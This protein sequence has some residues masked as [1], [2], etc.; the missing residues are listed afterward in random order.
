MEHYANRLKKLANDCGYK[1]DVFERLL[2][3]R[4]ATGIN[5]PQLEV[6][7]KQ[8]WPDL[9][10][11]FDGK[12]VEV[13]FAKFFAVAQ[14]RELAE[15]DNFVALPA[16][17][18][19]VR[20]KINMTQ[21]NQQSTFSRRLGLDQCRRCG[22]Y[23]RHKVDD[24][25]AR[26]HTCKECQTLGHFEDC[27]IKSGRAYLS[28]TKSGKKRANKNENKL[29]KIRNTDSDEYL[30]ESSDTNSYNSDDVFKIER[31]R[32]KDS[33]RI[34]VILNGVSCTLD[35]DPGSV[36]SIISTEFWKRIGTPPLTK[37]PKLRA[38]GNL[39]LKPKG[40]TDVTV[41]VLGRKKILPVV[42]MEDANPMLFGLQWSEMFDMTFPEPVYSVKPTQ[43]DTRTLKQISNTWD[44]QSVRTEYGRPI[45]RLKQ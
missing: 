5:H 41:E 23:E 20:T 17:T 2:R 12:T 9:Q 28:S 7:L 45:P 8:K 10:E 18:N 44:T 19:K 24:C 6:D 30:S 16:A 34:D 27:C 37:A 26:D 25:K 21:R 13:T 22:T 43:R 11:H 36:Y 31:K 3:D 33:K 42:V 1:D 15:G 38:Y 40:L 32:N 39:K 35:W 14:S 4:F 29:H